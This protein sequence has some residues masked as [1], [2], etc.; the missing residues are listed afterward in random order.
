MEFS[1]VIL[2]GELTD[3]SCLFLKGESLLSDL[4]LYQNLHVQ[5]EQALQ[6]D[7]HL[8]LLK[9]NY[10]KVFDNDTKL[11]NSEQIA[12]QIKLLLRANRCGEIDYQVRIYLWCDSYLL[13][14]TSAL[15][16][17]GYTLWHSRFEASTMVCENP[18]T[19]IASSLSLSLTEFALRRK[20]NLVICENLDHVITGV[21]DA[22]LFFVKGEIIYS[23]PLSYGVTHSVEREQA[24]SAIQQAG[25]NFQ[26]R[27]V[28]RNELTNF[29]EIFMVNT[30]GFISVRNLDS[31]F[32]YFS[33]T[34][35]ICS[36]YGK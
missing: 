26:P 35:R 15:L 5:G 13:A 8:D 32:Y 22:P 23:S 9:I 11:I 20:N 12:S 6:L 3:F 7:H 16:Y 34:Q 10:K 21:G 28:L 36:H 14:I 19:N 31:H 17:S 18:L 33:I 27:V 2:T 24:I 30:Q 25:F 1:K 4:Y 29:D